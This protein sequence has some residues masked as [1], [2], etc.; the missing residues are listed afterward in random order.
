MTNT[1]MRSPFKIQTK[2]NEDEEDE[3]NEKRNHIIKIF[4]LIDHMIYYFLM[5][6]IIC[7]KHKRME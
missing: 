3:K 6:L 2:T 5:K 1:P 7:L 4:N